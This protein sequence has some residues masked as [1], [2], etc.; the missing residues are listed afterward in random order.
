MY[1]IIYLPGGALVFTLL[2]R[3]RELKDRSEYKYIFEEFTSSNSNVNRL[4]L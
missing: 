3:E 4:L 1:F 2:E